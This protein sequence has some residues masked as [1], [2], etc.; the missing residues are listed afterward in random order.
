MS[1]PGT[2]AMHIL[3]E[4]IAHKRQEVE[5][6]ATQK[7]LLELKSAVADLPPAPGGRFKKALTGSQGQVALI[8]EIK[9]A[10]PSKGLIREDFSPAELAA[11][12]QSGGANALSVLTDKKYF[13]GEDR[14]LA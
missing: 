14:Y 8:A 1:A 11:A 3:D 2:Y 7:P 6:A 5:R 4:I 13:Q 9:K 10:S 12:Y